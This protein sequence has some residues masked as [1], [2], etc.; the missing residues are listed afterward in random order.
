[1]CLIEGPVDNNSNRILFFFRPRPNSP[2]DGQSRGPSSSSNRPSGST[3]STGSQ[4]S[5]ALSVTPSWFDSTRRGNGGRPA[6]EVEFGEV[7]SPGGEAAGTEAT[8]EDTGD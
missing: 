5:W 8:S 4:D 7:S 2:S 6:E 3:G 1:M